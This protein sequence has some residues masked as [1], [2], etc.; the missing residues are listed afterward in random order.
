M[1]YGDLRTVY[2]SRGECRAG[3][4]RHILHT[5]IVAVRCK[6]ANVVAIAGY[7]PAFVDKA[8][9]TLIGKRVHVRRTGPASAF[10]LPV[11]IHLYDDINEEDYNLSRM[12]VRLG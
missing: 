3:V 9:R 1:D 4:P 6:L 11:V 10:P 12:F 8:H 5:P 2:P 7:P